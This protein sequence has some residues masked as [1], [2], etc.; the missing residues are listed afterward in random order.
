MAHRDLGRVA[1]PCSNVNLPFW[2]ELCFLFQYVTHKGNSDFGQKADGG[3]ILPLLFRVGGSASFQASF[4]E[5]L[6]GS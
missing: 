6:F 1:V 5:A 4:P 2:L 3:G